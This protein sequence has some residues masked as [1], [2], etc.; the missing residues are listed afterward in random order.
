MITHLLSQGVRSTEG[1]V[2][3][4]PGSHHQ[5]LVS[6]GLADQLSLANTE[7]FLSRVEN[8]QG[9]SGGSQVANTAGVGRQLHRPLH[10][11]GIAGI[12]DSAAWQGL[13]HGQVLQR[14][15]AGT[16]LSDTDPAVRPHHVDVGLG[17]DAHPQVVEGPGEEG[18]ES[19]DEGNGSVPAGNSDT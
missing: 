15:L 11:Y 16:V 12:E 1:L 8:R 17:D 5:D 19:A 18:S 14:H 7:G 2:Q 9:W 3:S 10:G 13:E 4:H 6:G